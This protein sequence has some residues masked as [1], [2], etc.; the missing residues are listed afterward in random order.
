MKFCSTLFTAVPKTPF[1]ASSAAKRRVSGH[2]AALLL[3]VL[4][5]GL[6]TTAKADGTPVPTKDAAG[7]KDPGGLPRFTGSALFLREDVDYDE[8]TL[9]ASPVIYTDEAQTRLGSEKS[10][11]ASGTRSRLMYVAPEG[12]SSIELIRNYQA[13]LKSQGYASLFDCAGD[14]C[15]VAVSDYGASGFDTFVN[16]LYPRD[17]IKWEG[18]EA[19]ACA[20]GSNLTNTR[21]TLMQKAESGEVVAVFTHT[22]GIVSV[23]C[24]E[25]NW[26]K[27]VSATVVYFKPK[28]MEQNM[29]PPKPSEMSKALTETG[30][31]ALYGILFDTNKTELKPESLATIA[32]IAKLLSNEPKRRLIVVGHTDAVGNF[33]GNRDL[34]QRRAQAVVAALVAKHK[35]DAKRLLAFGASFSSPTASN[36]DEAGRAKNRRVELVS[37]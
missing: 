28:V 23:Y 4:T 13:Q 21:Y 20:G 11:A 3:A 17:Q 18:H 35:I 6:A 25:E 22:P 5:L 26:K 34:S 10:V 15:G 14:A 16:L 12:R 7:L 2:A 27:H 8:L 29:T 32:E 31:V 37:F 9:P 33:E 30:R 24:D 1:I 19:P 36:E